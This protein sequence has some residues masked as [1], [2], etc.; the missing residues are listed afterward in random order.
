M[1]YLVESLRYIEKRYWAVLLM[2]KSLCNPVDKAM[3]LLCS[4]VSW[5]VAELMIG[6]TTTQKYYDGI[7][8]TDQYECV[9]SKLL[10]F[11][12]NQLTDGAES[13]LLAGRFLVHIPITG[14][15]DLTII[16]LLEELNTKT[17]SVALSSERALPTHWEIQWL[18]RESKPRP[19]GVPQHFITVNL[20]NNVTADYDFLKRRNKVPRVQSDHLL[21]SCS[22][23]IMKLQL[24]MKQQW[25]KEDTVTKY[26]DDWDLRMYFSENT[27]VTNYAWPPLKIVSLLL[28]TWLFLSISRQNVG[29]V[30]LFESQI[31]FSFT[32]SWCVDPQDMKKIA[33]NSL[34]HHG[35]YMYF[36]N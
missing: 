29:C 13:P 3:R 25:N 5:P 17:N 1:P 23:Q 2:F 27:L 31:F 11:L 8:V 9:T 36:L 28:N 21:Y 18:N 7:P 19:S 35:Y 10:H 33:P 4:G 14:W 24:Y 26:L 16:A 15:V 6:N 20:Q 12:D 22:L 34:K 30:S 32:Y